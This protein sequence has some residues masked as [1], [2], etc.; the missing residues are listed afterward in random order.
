M[1]QLL[2]RGLSEE[3]KEGLRIKAAHQGHSMEAEARCVL[4][5]HALPDR[6]LGEMWSALAAEVREMGGVRLATPNRVSS[7]EVAPL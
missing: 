6:S 5:Q 4:T 3:A 2:V 7:R 1:A